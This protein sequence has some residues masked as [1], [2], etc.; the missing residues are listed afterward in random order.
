MLALKVRAIFPSRAPVLTVTGAGTTGT[1]GAMNHLCTADSA[2]RHS[3]LFPGTALMDPRASSSIIL[4]C[5]A[6]FTSA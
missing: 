4:K 3:A 5:E 1:T 2:G 6:G